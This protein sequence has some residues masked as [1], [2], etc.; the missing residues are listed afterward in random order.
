VPTPVKTILELFRPA[1]GVLPKL[2]MQSREFK[3]NLIEDY[4]H[5][6]NFGL[7][8]TKQHALDRLTWCQLMEA[9]MST[10]I[11]CSGDRERGERK[12]SLS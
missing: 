1:F 3:A 12:S 7:A 10:L 4:L 11:T 8:M 9:A 6:L 2:S 5:P